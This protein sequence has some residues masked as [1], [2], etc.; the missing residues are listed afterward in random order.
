MQVDDMFQTL[1]ATTSV[2]PHDAIAHE[3][4]IAQ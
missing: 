3:G 2:T 4:W 1:S